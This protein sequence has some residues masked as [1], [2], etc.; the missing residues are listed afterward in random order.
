MNR[1]QDV[2][3]PTLHVSLLSEDAPVLNRR[4]KEEAR[5]KKHLAQRNAEYA[6]GAHQSRLAE[7]KKMKLIDAQ[8]SSQ[9]QTLIGD[10]EG[11]HV[12]RLCAPEP[13]ATDPL[14]A[15]ATKKPPLY[16]REVSN[17]VA[18]SSAVRHPPKGDVA[19]TFAFP[20]CTLGFPLEFVESGFKSVVRWAEVAFD[21]T[22]LTAYGPRSIRGDFA[23]G[24]APQRHAFPHRLMAAVACYLLNEV[25]CREPNVAALWETK[26]RQPIFDAIFSTNTIFT[27][28]AVQN[29]RV[30]PYA[31]AAAAVEGG[32]SGTLDSPSCFVPPYPLR[33]SQYNHLGDYASMRLWT[34]EVQQEHATAAYLSERI[35]VLKNTVRQSQLV[36][37]M[38]QRKSDMSSMRT[39]FLAWRAYTAQHEK[40]RLAMERYVARRNRNALQEAVF[41]RW[42]RITLN[43]KIE[44]LNRR[45]LNQAASHK[46]E[47]RD[48]VFVSTTLKQQL[49]HEQ[50][51]HQQTIF[52]H[53]TLRTQMLE[54][55]HL[56]IQALQLTLQHER[57]AKTERV[58]LA[59]RWERLS[60]TFRPQQLCPTMS[61]STFQLTQSLRRAE[62]RIADI[63]LNSGPTST[64]TMP[65][66]ALLPARQHLERFLLRWVNLVMKDSPYGIVWTVVKQCEGGGHSRSRGILSKSKE[67]RDRSPSRKKVT[68][69]TLGTYALMCLVRELRRI[70]TTMNIVEE[71]ITANSDQR[72]LA[73]L[74]SQ[75]FDA[76]VEDHEL[77]KPEDNLKFFEELAS[78]IY[79]Q[80]SEGLY[81][82]L[83]SHLES[84][85]HIFTPEAIF[86]TGAEQI[87]SRRATA[88]SKYASTAA[89]RVHPRRHTALLWVLSTLFV[90]H[91]RLTM[92]APTMGASL[93]PATFR[94]VAEAAIEGQVDVGITAALPVGSAGETEES[95]I[96]F[97]NARQ[98]STIVSH[99]TILR[100]SSS[101][102]HQGLG[103]SPKPLS[104][105]RKQR[106]VDMGI[107][108]YLHPTGAKYDFRDAYECDT[109]SD[110]EVY[111]GQKPSFAANVADRHPY[112]SD[113]EGLGKNII[114]QLY[115]DFF[116]AEEA[117][118]SHRRQIRLQQQYEATHPSVKERNL[119]LPN[120]TPGQ[121]KVKT[122]EADANPLLDRLLQPE[123]LS[124]HSNS[125]SWMSSVSSR[126]LVVE[127]FM[128]DKNSDR[129]DD[130]W[131]NNS[132][133]PISTSGLPLQ[134]TV[135]S[136]EQSVA[137]PV[138]KPRT[139]TADQLR[140]LKLLPPPSEAYNE[141][142][143]PPH[144]INIQRLSSSNSLP[145]AGSNGAEPED[146][147]IYSLLLSMIDDISSRRNW[148]GAARVVTSL[149]LRFRVLD[150]DQDFGVANR[151]I[152]ASIANS[153][154]SS[155]ARQ[156]SGL[157]RPLKQQSYQTQ[158]KRG[159]QEG[160]TQ[161]GRRRFNGGED[162]G[163]AA[164]GKSEVGATSPFS[165][166][167][168]L[169]TSSTSN[170]GLHSSS[171]G[172]YP[173]STAEE[174]QQTNL[175]SV[176]VKVGDKPFSPQHS[177]P[178]LLGDVLHSRGG[179][180]A[181]A[182]AG[183]GGG[184]ASTQ[185]GG[186]G[187]ASVGNG[188]ASVLQSS[189][190]MLQKS[191]GSSFLSD[192]RQETEFQGLP[193]ILSGVDRR[194]TAPG[195]SAPG[196]EQQG[197]E[198]ASA[199]TEARLQRDTL[200]LTT[201]SV[202]SSD[203]ESQCSSI[204]LVK[205]VRMGG[206]RP[207]NSS[208][209]SRRRTDFPSAPTEQRVLSTS[210]LIQP[211]NSSV[212]ASAVTQSRSLPNQSGVL[213]S[214]HGVASTTASSRAAPSGPTS[215]PQGF[216]SPEEAEVPSG[217]LD[218]LV[219]HNTQ[220]K[221]SGIQKYHFSVTK[222]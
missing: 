172:G 212:S 122:E 129:I 78:L 217:V 128:G 192:G 90:G 151:P 43:S 119:P 134:S 2:P 92:L 197:C 140:L 190:L 113:A 6:R 112:N 114:Q 154:T 170:T 11:L 107:M 35:R 145:S 195:H 52:Q 55:H 139:L 144:A 96:F 103:V 210:G 94:C 4:C 40:S 187:M 215:S 38:A 173:D 59:K 222:K 175:K 101:P 33:T 124:P 30:A 184:G 8:L 109:V 76:D 108:D 14:T 75:S 182:A 5:L 149:V 219:L 88:T 168:G 208:E 54:N 148:I 81:P 169:H 47:M 100:K 111:I 53:E 45:V 24:T 177:P 206:G 20:L 221:Q 137:S 157:Y 118:V 105:Q 19:S 179:L 89:S 132:A 21:E 57:D 136:V 34:E 66:S 97:Q 186:N 42:R 83:L 106:R 162:A 131:E 110:V 27:D 167:M 196:A 99:N 51:R 65:Y 37:R 133:S 176:L 160:I 60:K 84:S 125:S 201:S 216:P 214:S 98:G 202:C 72:S 13:A 68:T 102:L 46:D 159:S 36:M 199:E 23:D 93:I 130:W 171:G 29:G 58:K 15:A 63:V 143:R 126:S 87:R 48:T 16:G 26:L 120:A 79:I 25:L 191:S 3:L 198:A 155:L 152:P 28:F 166:A 183:G 147:H 44:D 71:T 117:A 91:I 41:L 73:L 116:T 200:A 39:V 67:G 121:G 138:A 123:S 207:S 203:R 150:D 7:A 104:K 127:D 164:G 22:Y 31:A 205:G 218:P 1:N 95:G 189:N 165:E 82:S 115:A 50:A 142:R 220:R 18:D 135:I 146:Y 185:R 180:Q 153:H 70:Y 141:D 209:R 49:E 161:R 188:V 62:D 64:R 32:G 158:Q 69:A 193:G 61:A 163:V 77:P 12:P 211:Q 86:A 85:R 174:N 9:F 10:T 74:L 156:V 17:R 213:S 56:D 204:N 80:T 178:V 194:R 181:A